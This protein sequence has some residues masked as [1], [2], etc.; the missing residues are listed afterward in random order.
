MG[1]FEGPAFHLLM[2]NSLCCCC[3]S[4]AGAAG[5]GK[6]GIAH[7]Q[8]RS[9]DGHSL[10]LV[11]AHSSVQAGSQA[12]TDSSAQQVDSTHSLQF[13]GVQSPHRSPSTPQQQQQQLSGQ[14]LGA[15][16]GH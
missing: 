4:C 9:Q 16:G 1:A 11:A 7:L 12:G 13:L 5:A 10:S 14:V 8:A 15:A 2:H 6:T 3:L